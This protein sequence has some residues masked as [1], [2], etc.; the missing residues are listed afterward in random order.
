MGVYSAADRDP[1]L[2]SISISIEV[3]AEGNLQ[4]QD[5]AEI[6]EVKAFYREELPLGNLSH[7]HDRQLQDYLNGL[8]VIA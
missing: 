6:S 2:H 4:V 1:R 8:T 5:T 7:D 3:I